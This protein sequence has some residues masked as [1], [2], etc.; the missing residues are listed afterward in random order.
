MR[1]KLKVDKMKKVKIKIKT[2]DLVVVRTGSYRGVEDY[3]SAIKPQKQVAYLKK[4]SR[5]VYDKKADK[6]KDSVKK[7]VMIPIHVSNLS[8]VK[9]KSE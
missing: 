7:D 6:K 8:L 9:P 3:V 2:G 1:K 4:I 5:K